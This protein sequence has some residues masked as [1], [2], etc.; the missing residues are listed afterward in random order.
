MERV[1]SGRD[2][3]GVDST[4]LNPIECATLDM[5]AKLGSIDLQKGE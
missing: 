5:A 4:C 3:T 2:R 1:S